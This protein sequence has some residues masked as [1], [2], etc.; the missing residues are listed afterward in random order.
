[1]GAAKALGREQLDWQA[2]SEEEEGDHEGRGRIDSMEPRGESVGVAPA[3]WLPA[4][5]R[6]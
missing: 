4:L 3:P 2:E 1:M 5:V 6:V